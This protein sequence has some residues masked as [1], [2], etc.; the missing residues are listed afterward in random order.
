MEKEKNTIK[1][2]K[3]SEL[4]AKLESL[5]QEYEKR[6]AKLSQNE[7]EA[8][9]KI[10]DITPNSDD[11]YVEIRLF[12]DSDRYS[13]DVLVGINGYMCKI[14]RG[15]NVKVKRKFAKLITDAE[16]NMSALNEQCLMRDGKMEKYF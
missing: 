7:K 14:K 8:K 10:K 2:N 6:L 15:V 13:D 11:D 3:I 5:T 4:E 1:E 16:E 12:K 9:P